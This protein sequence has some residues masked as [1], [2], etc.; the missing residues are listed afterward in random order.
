[1]LFLF[2]FCLLKHILSGDCFKKETTVEQVF[3]FFSFSNA[4]VDHGLVSTG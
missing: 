2:F 3:I 1:M 4:V